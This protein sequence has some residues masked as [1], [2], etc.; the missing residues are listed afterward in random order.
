MGRVTTMAEVYNMEARTIGILFCIMV[1][2]LLYIG[3]KKWISSTRKNNA[4]KIKR[5]YQKTIDEKSKKSYIDEIE[6]NNKKEEQ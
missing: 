2:I 6:R 5:A 1:I 3:T 4:F